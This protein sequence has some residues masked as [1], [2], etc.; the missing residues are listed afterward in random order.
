MHSVSV[1]GLHITVNCI[2]T[3]SVAQQ[4]FYSELLSLTTMKRK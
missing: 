2:Q 3:V 1:V 4:C